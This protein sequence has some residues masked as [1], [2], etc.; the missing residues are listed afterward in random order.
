MARV[1]PTACAHCGSATITQETDVL[2]TWFSSGLLPVSVFGWPNLPGVL[3]TGAPGP[4]HLGT[5]ESAGDRAD[6]DAFYPTSLLV[7]GFDILFFWV[8]RMI[9][10]GC[11][12]AADVP[13]PAGRPRALAD[14]VPGREV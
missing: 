7:T 4:S 11:W 3:K 9:M 12:F 8:A 14:S 2:D 1:D 13:M 10:L 6:F 5:G